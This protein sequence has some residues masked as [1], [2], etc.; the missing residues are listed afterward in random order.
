MAA[1]QLTECFFQS[2]PV[3]FPFHGDDGRHIV[4]QFPAIHLAEDIQSFL[5]GRNRIVGARLNSWD[6]CVRKRTATFDHLGDLCYGR[7]LKYRT[8]R[9]IGT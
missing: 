8:Q 3:Q 7:L 2:L 4:A 5:C 6:H 1:D 9:D